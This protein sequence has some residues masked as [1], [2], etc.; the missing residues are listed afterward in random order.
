MNSRVISARTGLIQA[1]IPLLEHEGRDYSRTLVV[2]PGRRPAHFLRKELAQRAGFGL[3]PPRILSMDGFTDMLY[4]MKEAKPKAGP[5]DAVAV[6]YEIHRSSARPLG[7]DAFLTL[8]RFF[9]LGIR[10]F[11]DIEEMLIEGIASRVVREIDHIAA[12]AVPESALF[13]LQS[14]SHF[15]ERFY[16]R[17]DG[18]GLSTRSVR[19]RA[20]ADRIAGGGLDGFSRIVFAGFFALTDAEKRMFRLLRD[21]DRAF[22]LFVRAE[23]L[24]EQ[25]DSIGIDAG[26]QEEEAAPE[27]SWYSSPDTHGQVYSLGALL[28][29]G[30]APDES[31][32]IV[33]PSSGTLFPLIRQGIPFIPEEDYN[34]SMGHPL[35]RTPIFGFFS[36]LMQVVGSIDADRVYVPDYLNFVLHPYTKNIFF[37][38]SA[39]AT[40]ILFHGLEEELSQAG[41]RTFMTLDEIEQSDRVFDAV[42]ERLRSAGIAAG[43]GEMKAHLRQIHDMTVRQFLS[44]KNVSA[45]CEKCISLLTTV[46]HSSSARLHPLFHPFSEAFLQ[47]FEEMSGSL[48][49]DHSFSDRG[50][51]FSLLK[52]SL[53][54]GRVPFDGTPVKGLQILGFLETRGL[55][56]DR[57]F[58]LDVNEGVLPETGREDS[59]LPFQAR[60][61]LGMPTYLERDRLAAYHF[62]VLVSGAREVHLFFR[63]G[64]TSE[65]S[66]FA[67]RLIWRQQKADGTIKDDQYIRPVR[68]QVSLGN[69]RPDA[70]PKT[71]EVAERLRQRDFSPTHLDAYLRCPLQF[72]HRYVLGLSKRQDVSGDIAR[73][74]IG[75]TVHAILA[76]YFGG[77]TGRKLSANDLSPAA[78]DETV[79][80]HFRSQ[81]GPELVGPQYLLRRQVGKQLQSLISRYYLPLVS[82]MPV[83]VVSCESREAATVNGFRLTGRIDSIEQRGD[84]TLIIDYKTGSPSRGL[85][86]HLDQLDPAVR[87]TWRSAIGSIQLPFY[88]MLCVEGRGLRV[89]SLDAAYLFLGRSLIDARIEERLFGAQDPHSGYA[90]LRQVVLSLLA[91]IVDPAVAFA[92][93]ADLKQ[94]CPACDFRSLCGTQWIVRK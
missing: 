41:A 10:I 30:P 8:D 25:L 15:Y 36:S 46:Y 2:F 13:L 81:F 54:S 12:E 21:D 17:I 88:L 91:E 7:S 5:L 55:R 74:D 14:L 84:R 45:F 68:Y 60:R 9:P 33:L 1:V 77:M 24:A 44:F 79:G 56:F 38:G 76:D 19:Y 61:V 51:Y 53:A 86:V 72:Y 90:V 83:T 26:T 92:P 94:S 52:K 85:G 89:E 31:T 22:F 57:V 80:R 48:L 87:D 18:H 37:R 34:I 32:A 50:S 11:R 6:L 58:I 20:A 63:E 67:E 66:R 64:D 82:A 28:K 75:T 16:E 78:M 43:P 65:R 29:D 35:V 4:E 39:D 42:A 27:I 23:G 3:I 73:E 49:R 40:R 93:A 47:V 59:L 69:A 71:A 62:D 70:I